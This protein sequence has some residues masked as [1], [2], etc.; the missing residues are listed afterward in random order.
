M[1]AR[2]FYIKKIEPFIDKSPIKV[3]VGIRRSGKSFIMG[4]IKDILLK[5]GVGEDQIIEVNFESRML[6]FAKTTDAIYEFVKTKSAKDPQKRIYLLF[7]EIQEVEGWET[8]INAVSIDF[9]VDIYLTGSNAKLL[10]GELA[11]Y[12]AG[13]YVE[14]HV[15]PLSFS[16]T[17]PCYRADNASITVREAFR[18]YVRDGGLPFVHSAGMAGEPLCAYVTDVFNSVLLKDIAKRHR[19]RDVD[20]LER[21]LSYLIMEVGHLFS[22]QSIVK[23]LKHENR[24]VSLETLYNYLRYANESCLAVTLKRND[25]AGK[26]LL[27]SQEKVY[28]ADH[29]FR[30]ALF[31]NNEACI[32]QILENIVAV[33]LVRRGY[34][35]TVGILGGKEV[36]FVAERAGRKIY[37]QVAYLMPTQ[38]VRDR[39]FSVLERIADNFPKYVLSM[40]E[41]DFSRNGIIH[42]PIYDF[43]L[44]AENFNMSAGTFDS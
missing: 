36:D 21:I 3:L 23:F 40:D 13:R 16:E 35:V 4:F 42:K 22:A 12:L 41:M 27:S 7:D 17:L 33:D 2:P 18:K 37:I 1:I 8:L 19:I 28:L 34:D 32:D 11:T 38:E 29:G 15:Y 20:M 43:L 31:G 14:I 24:G 10:S 39:E 30:E 5:R 25:L 9:K 44:D 6:P 26:Q